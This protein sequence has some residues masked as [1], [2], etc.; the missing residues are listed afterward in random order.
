MRMENKELENAINELMRLK[1]ILLVQCKEDVKNIIE[2]KVTE[3]NYIESTL[4]NTAA[5]APFAR[6]NRATVPERRASPYS[7][8]NS[9]LKYSRHTK[10]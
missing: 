7:G 9:M 4:V 8:K 2:N 1:K 3:A 5:R 10:V 6:R